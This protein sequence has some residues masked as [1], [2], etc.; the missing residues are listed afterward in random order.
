[1]VSSHAD[2]DILLQVK[3]IRTIAVDRTIQ[4]FSVVSHRLRLQKALRSPQD[5]MSLYA[6][7]D[8]VFGDLAETLSTLVEGSQGM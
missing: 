7:Y 3:A 5:G 6:T 4:S 1:M 2:I 8:N